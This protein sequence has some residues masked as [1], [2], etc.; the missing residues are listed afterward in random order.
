MYANPSS[1]TAMPSGALGSAMRATVPSLDPMGWF[2]AMSPDHRF[3]Y[4]GHPRQGRVGVIEKAVIRTHRQCHR[5]AFA[6]ESCDA[7]AITEPDD[8]EPVVLVCRVQRRPI[9][10]HNQT[11]RPAAEREAPQHSVP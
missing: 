1:A 4:A 9:R 2:A 11:L 6:F 5:A 3:L 7:F 10:R 8:V